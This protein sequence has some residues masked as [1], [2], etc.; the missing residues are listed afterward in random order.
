[1]SL[2]KP[3]S[4]RSGRVQRLKESRGLAAKLWQLPKSYYELIII[5]LDLYEPN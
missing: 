1:M 2:D 4:E 5:L 3:E